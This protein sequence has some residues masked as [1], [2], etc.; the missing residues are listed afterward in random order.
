MQACRLAV[1]DLA[2]RRG[3]RVLFRGLGAVLGP[4]A[5][6][7]L[8]GPNGVGKSSLIRILAG[9]LAPWSGTVERQ[10]AAALADDR[11]ALD[12]H[13]TLGRALAFW[14]RF[15]AVPDAAA[16]RAVELLGLG[17]LLEVPVAYLSTGQRK[18]A[19][20]ARTWLSDA[21]IWLLDE[22]LNGLD[23]ASARAVADAIA[24]HAGGGGIA[25]V[26][27]HQPLAIAGLD[28]LELDRFAVRDACA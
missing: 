6:L 15:D 2:C 17:E 20:L 5:A 1:S 26:A 28:V 12:P 22:P 7:H 4:G 14:R 19:G 27:S 21:P 11:S 13:R 24:R 9:L 8:S 3:D 25:V 23:A 16:Q 18:R 10:G